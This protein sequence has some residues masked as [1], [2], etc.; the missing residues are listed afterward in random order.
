MKQRFSERH[1]FKQPPLL[2]RDSMNDELRAGLWNEMYRAFWK[3]TEDAVSHGIPA[4]SRTF[5][6]QMWHDFFRVPIDEMPSAFR[7]ARQHVREWFLKD[8]KWFQAYDFVEWF[9][10]NIPGRHTREIFRGLC[11]GVLATERSAWRFVGEDLAPISSEQ[12]IA[13]VETALSLGGEF[14][15][16][17]THFEAAVSCFSQRPEPDVRNCVKEAISAVESAAKLVAGPGAKGAVLASALDRIKAPLHPQFRQGMKNLYNYTSDEDGIRHGLMDDPKL[18][19]DDARFMLVV[20]SAFS[21]YLLAKA[22]KLLPGE[23]R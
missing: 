15:V 20:C 23:D 18:D 9:A 21:N 17:R 22:G 19:V 11:N 10:H 1:G 16:V 2:Q 7:G 8:A 4:A 14:A 13:S 6:A 12:E 3:P 5:V